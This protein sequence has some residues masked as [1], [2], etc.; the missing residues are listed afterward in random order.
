[1]DI[2]AAKDFKPLDLSQIQTPHDEIDLV[3]DK[4]LGERVTEEM[5]DALRPQLWWVIVKQVGIKKEIVFKNGQ[6]LILTDQSVDEQQWA[7]GMCVVV[8]CGPAVYRGP[9]FEQ[10]G[11]TP[12]DGPQPGKVYHFSARNPK[13]YKVDGETFIEVPDDALTTEFN[14]EQLH[15]VDFSK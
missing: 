5:I 9:K 4:W 2:A 13:R 3:K 7:V 8:K 15:L 6:K 10:I 1:M 14:R 11:L 12:E